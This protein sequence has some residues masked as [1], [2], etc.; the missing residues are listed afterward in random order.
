MGIRGRAGESERVIMRDLETTG[1]CW[2]ERERRRE[3]ERRKMKKNTYMH[4]LTHAHA[5]NTKTP[6]PARTLSTH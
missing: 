2:G 5:L 4:T 6:A 1:G 3:I